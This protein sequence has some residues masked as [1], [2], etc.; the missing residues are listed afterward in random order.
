MSNYSDKTGT[1][2]YFSLL[3]TLIVCLCLSYP[4]QSSPC[5]GAELFIL[6]HPRTINTLTG[7]TRPRTEL[8]ISSEVSGRCLFVSGDIGDLI[9]ESSPFIRI[10]PTFILLDIDGNKLARE[11]LKKK[12]SINKQELNR[13]TK[14]HTNQSVPQAKFD[15]V[16]LQHEL[17][18]IKLKQLINTGKRLQELFKR[19]VVLAPGGYRIID[20]NVE[21]GELINSGQHLATLGDFRELLIPL[22]LTYHE[23]KAL[24]SIS[25]IP[26]FLPDL[27]LTLQAKLFRTAPDF[28]KKSRK[29]KIELILNKQ[30]TDKLSSLRGGLRVLIQ[31]SMLDRTGSYIVPASAIQERHNY[32]WLTKSD[33]TRKKVVFLGKAK[34]DDQALI[35]G[36]NLVPG[37]QFLTQP[38]N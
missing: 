3:K 8:T 11:Q 24:N 4:L 37:E 1:S 28:D 23:Y 21:P 20:K 29:I 31:I 2:Y 38:D 34:E 36:M 22:V 9:D 18:V 7:F 14:L 6:E 13:Y 35:S 33:G 12:I 16:S 30:Q 17:S 5:S 15:Q 10:D 19:H 26:V 27:N 32:F 25:I